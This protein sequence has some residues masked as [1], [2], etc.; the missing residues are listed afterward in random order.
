MSRSTVRE[1][2]IQLGQGVTIQCL[3][4]WGEWYY[5]ENKP[6]YLGFPKAVSFLNERVQG[7]R[8]IVDEYDTEYADEEAIPLM[9]QEALGKKPIYLKVADITYSRCRY[10]CSYPEKA[11]LLKQEGYFLG[12][13]KDSCRK[14]Y[15]ALEDN[16][17]SYIEGYLICQENENNA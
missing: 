11:N 2:D 6:V 10:G 17:H 9:I 15:Q 8:R 3:K 4:S 14:K 5:R 12:S 16:L 1:P 13:S 7:L